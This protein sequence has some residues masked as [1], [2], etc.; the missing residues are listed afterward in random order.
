MA[1]KSPE[2][3]LNKI[4]IIIPVKDNQIGIN[5][6]LN[7]FFN[8]HQ[9]EDYPK[10]II[11]VDN[12]SKEP[13]QITSEFRNK[14][15]KI[16]LINCDRK[17]PASA[18]NQ[19]VKISKGD[20]ILFLDSDCFATENT[21]KGYLNSCNGSVAYAGMVKSLGNDLISRYYEEQE[22][23]M[24][25]KVKDNQGRFMPQYLIT[26]N[27][28]IWKQAFNEVGG[29]NE[30][31]QLAGGEDV[32]LGLRL[33]EIGNLS[34]AFNAI[35]KH[36]FDDGIRGFWNRFIRYGQGNRIVEEIYK[37]DLSP[38]LFRPNKRTIANEILAKIQWLGLKI[39]YEKMSKKIKMNANIV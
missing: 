30:K 3:Q 25:L 4:S 39:G 7:S 28:L 26:A 31:I 35:V 10:E 19:G 27:C 38:K 33:S 21:I 2:I 24:P 5:D 29:F 37:S 34:F 20:W 1:K 16:I 11:I 22:I 13:I 17:G 32:D 36:N 9:K 23:L 15:I 14:E 6:F 8:T 18:R 12:L